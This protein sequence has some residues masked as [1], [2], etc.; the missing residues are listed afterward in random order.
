MHFCNG[1]LR[2][3][4]GASHKITF[5]F[6]RLWPWILY[7]KL[8]VKALTYTQSQGLESYVSILF[9]YPLCIKVYNMYLKWQYVHHL[10]LAH[11]KLPSPYRHAQRHISHFHFLHFFCMFQ[12]NICNPKTVSLSIWNNF[13]SMPLVYQD[14]SYS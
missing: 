2:H 3:M 5:L 13:L 4:L 10:K 8:F 12:H 1:L 6:R 9:P 14:R 7:S 11:F